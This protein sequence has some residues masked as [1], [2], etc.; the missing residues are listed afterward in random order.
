MFDE[1][2]VESKES[3]AES[4]GIG[5]I[6]AATSS[7]C[8]GGRLVVEKGCRGIVIRHGERPDGS[9]GASV[10]FQGR[11]DGSDALVLCR[12]CEI[13]VVAKAAQAQSMTDYATL[14]KGLLE[15]HVR[16]ALKSARLSAV[17]F[18]EIVT[19][20]PTQF[21]SGNG[22]QAQGPKSMPTG[23]RSLSSHASKLK[24]RRKA[25]DGS[26]HKGEDDR[27]DDFDDTSSQ[28]SSQKQLWSMLI[29]VLVVMN[30]LLAF[31][32]MQ[33]RARKHSLP[34][35][36]SLT[37]DSFADY[38]VAHPSGTLVNFFSSSCE[39]CTRLAPE[40]EEAAK[41]LQETTN[42][43]LASVNARLAPST[44]KQYLIKSAPSLLW[45]RQG[46]L[47]RD[48]PHSVRSVSQILEFVHESL[49][50]ALIE[51]SSYAEFLESMPQLR[52]VLQKGKT[53]PIVAGFGPD[54]AVHDVLEQVG[55]KFRGETAFLFVP[56]AQQ[57]D[58][59]IRA[60][61]R[62]EGTD[63]DYNGSLKV[64]E[65]LLWLKPFMVT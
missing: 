12:P 8:I 51:F 47:V 53:P 30:L 1:I 64:D 42:V 22:T 33:R 27:E 56:E 24:H 59:S 36:K 58:P 3:S 49:Q 45:F 26:Q 2:Q 31:V 15:H 65:F 55:E 61:F 25:N 60:Y 13:Q 63:K 34:V 5:D 19:S 14:F 39:P 38:I 32:H 52:A 4:F 54:P 18:C 35:V 10:Q 41:Q 37:D 23:S 62:D 20:F 43:S 11:K 40:F 28:P 6:V 21:L 9:A 29:V 7:F 50:P 57:N 48:V 44:V 16:R 17:A 46:R